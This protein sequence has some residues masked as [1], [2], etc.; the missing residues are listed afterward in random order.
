MFVGTSL[1]WIVCVWF[2]IFQPITQSTQILEDTERTKRWLAFYLCFS[3]LV[4]PLVYLLPV[5]FP[6]RY[7]IIIFIL[8]CLSSSDADGALGIY[9][10]LI[11]PQIKQYAEYIS[12]LKA[13]A[14]ENTAPLVVIVPSPVASA[15]ASPVGEEDKDK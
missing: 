8:T 15:V 13:L 3:V 11:V 6:F 9:N 2:V 4:I 12:K 7:E 5:W 14:S 10:K 1:G